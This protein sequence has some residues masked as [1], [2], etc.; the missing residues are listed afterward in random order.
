MINEDIANW[1]S[2]RFVEAT[3]RQKDLYHAMNPGAKAAGDELAGFMDYR[4]VKGIDRLIKVVTNPAVD[5]DK[6][7]LVNT[8]NFVVEE[9]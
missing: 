6:M 4:G 9:K 8:D 2:E 1:L 5:R 3:P 7:L